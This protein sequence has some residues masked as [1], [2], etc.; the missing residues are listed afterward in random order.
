M[1]RFV[2]LRYWTFW[3][4]II[5]LGGCIANGAAHTVTGPHTTV[6][7]ADR[8]RDHTRRHLPVQ[9]GIA[10]W[11]GPRRNGAF[12]ASGQRFDPNKLTAAHNTL[13]FNTKA[14]VTNLRNGR[15]VE[16]TIN[17]RGPHIRGRVIDLSERAARHLG[18]KKKG[19]AMVEIDPI[20]AR[21]ASN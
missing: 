18:M 9:I 16:V 12:T 7:V 11:Y 10:S 19:L 6:H 20:P 2:W 3:V 4:P 15:T 8:G 17:D 13:P 5:L 14:R 21:L 1:G